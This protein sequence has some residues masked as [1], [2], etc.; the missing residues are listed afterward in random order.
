LNSQDFFNGTAP[1][2]KPT[3]FFFELTKQAKLQRIGS[4]GCAWFV[5]DL[6]E[7]LGEAAFPATAKRILFDPNLNAEPDARFIPARS[8]DDIT[9]TILRSKANAA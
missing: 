4:E 6:P 5:D 9:N 2:S 7:F 8:W 3:R 1:G